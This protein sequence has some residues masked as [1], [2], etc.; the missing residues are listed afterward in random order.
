MEQAHYR[1]A[2]AYQQAG[3]VEKART[4]IA[5]FQQLSKTSAQQLERDR[6][7]LQQF[8]VTLKNTPSN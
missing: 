8:V 7:E 1:L 3:E 5:I 4:E 2:Q 6:S